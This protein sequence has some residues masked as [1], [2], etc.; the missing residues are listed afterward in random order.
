MGNTLAE[1]R[2][3][4]EMFDIHVREVHTRKNAILAKDI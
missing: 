1:K 4:R 3:L 2:L